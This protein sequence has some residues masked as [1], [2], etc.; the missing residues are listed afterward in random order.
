MSSPIRKH[1][2]L[3]TNLAFGSLHLE[4][5]DSKKCYSSAH[6]SRMLFDANTN[7]AIYLG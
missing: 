5:V 2:F 3:E 4:M 7:S 1:T 6:F